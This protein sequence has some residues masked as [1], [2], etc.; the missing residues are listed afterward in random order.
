MIEF[1]NTKLQNGIRIV[2]E[3]DFSLK[4]FSLGFWFNTGSINE[5]RKNNGISHFI[6]HMLFKGTTKRTSK[7]I[8]DDIE[9]LGGYLNAFTS[10]EHTCY[11]GRG[12]SEH[13]NKTFEVIADMILNSVF[14]EKDILNESKVIL[15]E[16]YDI[17]DSPDE[18]IFDRFESELFKG[19]S[20]AYPVIGTET[21]IKTINRDMISDYIN[22]FYTS[23]NLTVSI[24]GP[25]SHDVIINLCDK[26]FGNF[27]TF[28]KIKKHKIKL[29]KS[30]DF[31]IES[32]TQQIHYITGMPTFGANDKK[33]TVVALLSHILGEG[34]SSRLFQSLREKNGIAYQINTFLNSFFDISSFGVYL[35][36]NKSSF[37]KAQ[38]L[39]KKEFDK[40]RAKKVTQK[41]LNR[42]K[43]YFIGSLI[44]NLES[45]TGR[46]NRN[47]Q[48]NIYWDRFKPIEESVKEIRA[49][50]SEEI[51]SVANEFI[52][53]NKMLDVV[54]G[55][56][57]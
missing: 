51:L 20:I 48:F 5:T 12:L 35:S 15:D 40:I 18:L 55:K 53:E 1:N 7:K 42:A 24:T 26:Y 46:M 56:N 37:K 21:N 27:N 39:I 47:A 13:L 22:K 31:K 23:N 28:S 25:F 8:A 34:S 17:D 4:T 19:N 11:Y 44:M 2:T 6:E 38:A 14:N 10:K 29:L 49:I 9:S 16:L 54:L 33:R 57:V 3:T 32:E 36:T 30:F 43:E 41:E 50:T 45:T 52:C